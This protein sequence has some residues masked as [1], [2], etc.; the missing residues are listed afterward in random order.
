MIVYVAENFGP[1]QEGLELGSK[2][3]VI[4]GIPFVFDVQNLVVWGMFVT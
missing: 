2:S 3:S 4:C 1:S